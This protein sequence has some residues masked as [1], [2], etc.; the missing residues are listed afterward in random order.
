M[1][2]RQRRGERAG[3]HAGARPEAR[4]RGEDQF[5]LR[6]RSDGRP[7]PPAMPTRVES[8]CDVRLTADSLGWVHV[9]ARVGNRYLRNAVPRPGERSFPRA[10]CIGNRG[11]SCGTIAHV[12]RDHLHH[13]V[14]RLVCEFASS[15]GFSRW[16][17]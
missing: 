6:G 3:G 9:A 5:V 13:L 7:S 16:R 1:S 17:W 8:G 15:P 4:V 11:A 12:P 2:T 14:R 10:V